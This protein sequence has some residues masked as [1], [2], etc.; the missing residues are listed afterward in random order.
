MNIQDLIYHIL[1]NAQTTL[2]E[3]IAVKDKKDKFLA[4]FYYL[5]DC[6]ILLDVSNNLSFLLSDYFGKNLV[7][8]NTTR[9]AFIKR[10][11]SK[12]L[13]EEINC[14]KIEARTIKKQY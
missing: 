12:Q 5:S 9:E 14:I 3:L 8:L 2:S 4:I 7:S 10:S 1:K 11:R 6:Y 13:V